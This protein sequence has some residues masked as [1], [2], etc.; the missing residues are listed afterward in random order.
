ML[1]AFFGK[2]IKKSKKGSKSKP[3][4]SDVKPSKVL[5]N[6]AHKLGLRTTHKVNGKRVYK[7]EK[8][9]KKQIIN[10]KKMASKKKVADLKKKLKLRFAKK[11][12]LKKSKYGVNGA[13]YMPLSK[14]MSK[15][16]DSLTSSTPFL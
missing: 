12:A 7:S 8:L 10:A 3:K 13:R 14:L 2:K 11:K 1:A 16:P 15:Y 9:L 4:K 6:R 5:R